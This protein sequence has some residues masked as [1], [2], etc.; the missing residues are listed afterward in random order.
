MPQEAAMPVSPLFIPLRIRSLALKNRIIMPGMVTN[1]AA[2]NG[3]VTE[4]LIRYHAERARGGVALN[5]VEASYVARDG[6]S[7]DF[8]LSVADD[9]MLPGLTRLA[10]AVH[11]EGGKIAIQL[12][13]GGRC[14]SPERSG[15]PRLLVSLVPDLATSEQSRI[16][17]RDDIRRLTR[18]WAEAAVRA[19][20]AGFDAVE[21]HAA[22]GY[23]PGQFL[24]PLTNT[25]NDEYGGSPE[26]RRRFLLEILDAMRAAL[27]EDFPILVR[28]SVD[29]CLPG[30]LTVEDFPPI[31]RALVEHGADLLNVSIGVGESVEY[32]IP[33]ST[34]PEGWNAERAA[35]IREAVQSRV[36][37]AVAGHI[38][39]R[40]VAESI[41]HAGQADLVV[42]GRALL[43]DPWLPRKL[44]QGRDE[45]IVPCIGCNEGCTGMLNK[46]RPISCAMN[47]RAGNEG[48]FSPARA[49][50]P[51]LIAIVGGGPAGL[52]AA[53]TAARGGHRVVLFEKTRQ[54]GGMA[55]VAALPPGKSALHRI[56]AYYEKILPALGVEIRL[57]TEAGTDTLR[58][59]GP[60][61]VIVATGGLPVVPG[62][63]ASVP[64][65]VL[66]RDVLTGTALQEGRVLLLG[67][68]L[69]GAECAH[70]LAEQGREVTLVEMRD[71]IAADM[72]YKTRQ[73]LLPR[74]ERLGVR[75][76][77][78]T[79]VLKLRADG[80]IVRTAWG[81]ERDLSGFGAVVIALGYRPDTSLCAALD[82]AGMAFSP[83][84]DCLRVGKIIDAI[85]GGFHLA[86]RL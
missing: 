5:I 57:Q 32:I 76:L 52:E 54:L 65:L 33:P 43:A 25:R 82:E 1:H 27:G 67:G 60:D 39:T 61:R 3:E 47:P 75:M 14:A 37:V 18:A 48:D 42:M 29:E 20:R 85:W 56:R 68:G 70:F 8:G 83:A 6:N 12:Q 64:A 26:N 16:I 50:S 51:K 58:A 59:L 11:E 4:K 23:L 73:F 84:G 21:L 19:R 69:V 10:R 44:E 41:L 17:D 49:G 81:A 13:H 15:L 35:A 71:A 55:D 24:S 46:R 77:V 86:R 66:A 40:K 34:V 62:F 9:A 63:C 80:A 53:R 38:R 31:A 78:N 72:E 79:E 36:P 74:L 7:F 22:H 2:P 45:D 30:G 28:L